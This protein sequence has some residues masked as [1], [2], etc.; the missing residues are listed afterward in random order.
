V[1]DLKNAGDRMGGSITAAHFLKE[2]VGDTPWV[3]LDIA[4]PSNVGKEKGY[5]NKGATGFGVR[6]LVE[7]VRRRTSELE[8]VVDPADDEG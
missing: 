8:S 4:G 2:F 3:H 7:F 1:A 6:T 5:L